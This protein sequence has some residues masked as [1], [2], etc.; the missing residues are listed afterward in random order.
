MSGNGHTDRMRLDLCTSCSD[1]SLNDA[2]TLTYAQWACEVDGWSDPCMLDARCE[3]CWADVGT[4]TDPVT[5]EAPWVGLDVRSHRVHGVITTRFEGLDDPVTTRTSTQTVSGSTV[6]GPSIVEA[7]G[8]RWE[9]VLYARDREAL[10]WFKRWFSDLVAGLA[11]GSCGRGG[12]LKVRA[13]CP[14]PGTTDLTAGLLSLVD[15]AATGGVKYEP[16][17][18][19]TW[20]GFTVDLT[21]GRGELWTQPEQFAHVTSKAEFVKVCKSCGVL[22]DDTIDN[23]QC[24]PCAKCG[25]PE[26]FEATLTCSTV[27]N[28]T[29]PVYVRPVTT[30]AAGHPICGP[31]SGQYGTAAETVWKDEQGRPSCGKGSGHYMDTDAQ[32]PVY[33]YRGKPSCG[34]G[35][36][37]YAVYPSRAAAVADLNVTTAATNGWVDKT[38]TLKGLTPC[39]AEAATVIAI[40]QAGGSIRDVSYKWTFANQNQAPFVQSGPQSS[41]SDMVPVWSGVTKTELLSTTVPDGWLGELTVNWSENV[42][43]GGT[44]IVRVSTPACDAKPGPNGG[45]YEEKDAQGRPSCGPGSEFYGDEVPVLDWAG[46]PS[47]G[48]TSAGY[49]AEEVFYDL[50]GK[51]SCGNGSAGYAQWTAEGPGN[52]GP[53][54]PQTITRYGNSGNNP[55]VWIIGGTGQHHMSKLTSVR[56]GPAS[57]DPGYGVGALTGNGTLHY[58]TK[59]G[60]W[61]TQPVVIN[62]PNGQTPAPLF[63][64]IPANANPEGSFYLTGLTG[65]Q[66]QFNLGSSVGVEIPHTPNR[67]VNPTDRNCNPSLQPTA[68]ACNI[69]P[70]EGVMRDC[71]GTDVECAPCVLGPNGGVDRDCTTGCVNTNVFIPD[72][73][74]GGWPAGSGVPEGAAN[75]P[76]IASCI[77]PLV[78]EIEGATVVGVTSPSGHALWT[79]SVDASP[80]MCSQDDAKI[81]SVRLVAKGTVPV[82]G[83]QAAGWTGWT[84]AAW[85]PITSKLVG[86]A[87][88]TLAAPPAV[89]D[90]GRWTWPLDVATVADLHSLDLLV[91]LGAPLGGTAGNLDYLAVEV[92]WTGCGTC[93]EDK[94]CAT[95]SGPVSC[96]KEPECCDTRMFC[97]KIDHLDRCPGEKLLPAIQIAAPL[98]GDI[99]NVKVTVYCNPDDLPN[100]TDDYDAWK[101]QTPAMTGLIPLIAAG[102]SLSIDPRTKQ[103]MVAD[104]GG[105]CQPV[106][107]A[108]EGWSFCPVTTP[109]VVCI[110]IDLC[111]WPEGSQV[112]IDGYGDVTT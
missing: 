10:E 1:V 101:C 59:A 88:T 2:Q 70:N 9:G 37:L 92:Q 46:I 32:L 47:C 50:N 14:E 55:P 54:T 29:P 5:D 12:E 104:R 39:Q 93:A 67:N 26:P 73:A 36:G 49:G 105:G 31:G 100:P 34:E 74:V 106:S 41:I 87:H 64:A 107:A 97:A 61:A 40:P 62:V 78:T 43:E 85:N 21:A 60:T 84:I 51:P 75:Y 108:V 52:W 20:V 103:I 83:S 38:S 57:L 110:Q 58:V 56:I 68:R 91:D 11:D 69:G 8:L 95:T 79:G 112:W 98:A 27:T 72:S 80:L 18:C 63:T 25:C 42:P 22:T 28:V 81:L 53:G 30:D 65:T 33:D 24:A 86:G 15:V 4:W 99:R 45:V 3:P 6:F 7:R 44:S 111:A 16:V 66:S 77:I 109:A 13:W 102:S 19:D 82:P 71:F 35:S 76:A 48:P 94:P 17:C 96:Y 90:K 89:D 23:E